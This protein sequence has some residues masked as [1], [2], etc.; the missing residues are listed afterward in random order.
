MVAL[1]GNAY[2]LQFH[3]L[4]LVCPYSVSKDVSEVEFHLS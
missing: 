3:N 2:L 1:K 4:T